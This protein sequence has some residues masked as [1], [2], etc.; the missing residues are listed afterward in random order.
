MVPV[1]KNIEKKW[2]TILTEQ[3][4]SHTKIKKL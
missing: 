2:N 1:N 3:E 4:K